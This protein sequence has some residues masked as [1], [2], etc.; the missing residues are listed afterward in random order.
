MGL[1]KFS[2]T[3]CG[4]PGYLAPEVFDNIFTDKCDI[5][6]AGCV[7][8][9]LLTKRELFIGK[10]KSEVIRLNKQCRVDFEILKIH[11]ITNEEEELLKGLLE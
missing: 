9:K 11:K 6:S 1:C 7:F 4:T 10:T 3:K 2:Y 5:F 8:Y